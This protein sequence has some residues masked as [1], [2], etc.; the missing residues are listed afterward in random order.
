MT[1]L[2]A[3]SKILVISCQMCL[4]FYLIRFSPNQTTLTKYLIF[5]FWGYFTCFKVYVYFLCKYTT[6]DF[7]LSQ[8]CCDFHIFCRSARL[9]LSS[10]AQNLFNFL[11]MWSLLGCQ[12]KCKHIFSNF[13]N[14]LKHFHVFIFIFLWG[15]YSSPIFDF[16]PPLTFSM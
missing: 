13:Q 16:F 2:S 7:F 11:C 5:I 12:N 14:I 3:D 15:I 10:V 1:H 9:L 4:C 8:C 6:R